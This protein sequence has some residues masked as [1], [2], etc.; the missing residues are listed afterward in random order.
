MA[1]RVAAVVPI[2]SRERATIVMLAA[3]IEL[4]MSGPHVEN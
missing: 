3:Q 4:T 2:P 1:D